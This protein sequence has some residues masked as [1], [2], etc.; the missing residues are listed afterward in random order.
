MSNRH[1][2]TLAMDAIGKILADVKEKNSM[3]DAEETHGAE[4]GKRPDDFAEA[5][6]LLEEIDKALTRLD[7]L[8]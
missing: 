1:Q 6:M 4:F 5:E 8:L 2:L 3:I 7:Y